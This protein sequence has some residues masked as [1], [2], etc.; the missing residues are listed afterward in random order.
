MILPW[1]EESIMC[2]RQRL[3]EQVLLPNA[4][5]TEICKTFQVSRKTAYKWLSRYREGGLSALVNQSKAPHKQ[6]KKIAAELEEQIIELHHKNPYWGG[7]KLRDHFLYV[8]ELPAMPS[9]ATFDRALKRNHCE[10]ITSNK[11]KPATTRFEREHPNDLWQMDFKGSFMTQN[12]RCY[13][14]TILD[15]CSRFSI[16]LTACDN[17]T[18]QVVKGHLSN[19]F[20][21]F[22][23]PKQINVDNGNPW[24]KSDLTSYTSLQVWLMKL[25]IIITHSAPFHPQT[26]GKNERFHRTLK[27]EILHQRSY[28]SSEIQGVFDDWRHKYNYQRP[29]EAL[30]G[31][32]PSHI[33]QASS[34]PFLEQLI[35]Y[36]Y[37]EGEVRKVHELNGTFRFKGKKFMAGKGFKGEYIALKETDNSEE[38]AVFFMDNLIKKINVSEGGVR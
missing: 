23:L 4:N 29:H 7:R 18:S 19:I 26:N 35:A 10:V 12:K 22:G 14:L 6:P 27:L 1:I 13:P 25:G 32:T 2:Q 37:D 9:H 5:V 33:Y 30:G 36:E 21:E 24:G 38:F 17:E 16:S 20:R 3:I 34:R 8:Q 31:R 11:S 15:D 28:K